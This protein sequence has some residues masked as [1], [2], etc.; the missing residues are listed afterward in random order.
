MPDG[1]RNLLDNVTPSPHTSSGDTA[2]PPTL[3]ITVIPQ[4]RGP[5]LDVARFE[6]TA[7]LGTSPTRPLGPKPA[8]PRQHLTAR[9]LAR[10]PWDDHHA[11]QAFSEPVGGAA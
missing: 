2:T 7:G 8:P 4:L 11:H 5:N 1:N 6:P 9:P 3:R 10:D